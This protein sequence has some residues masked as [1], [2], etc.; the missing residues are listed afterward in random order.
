VGRR[1]SEQRDIGARPSEAGHLAEQEPARR[2]SGR[3]RLALAGGLVVGLAA[4]GTWAL[5][6]RDDSSTA[7]DRPSASSSTSPSTTSAP[8]AL[9][10]TPTDAA[11]QLYF[12][13]QRGDQ[14]AAERLGTSAAIRAVFDIP[15]TSAAG[16]AFDGCSEPRGGSS[17]C[18]W[19]RRGARLTMT[20][21]APASGAPQVQTVELS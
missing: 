15:S 19:I 6:A 3:L 5:V 10:R 12:A 2:R 20:V 14:A 8:E 21:R 17:T 13:W 9:V 16:L 7:G 4:A 11:Q 18:S 1:S